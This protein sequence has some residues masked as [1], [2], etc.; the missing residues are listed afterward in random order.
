MNGTLVGYF[1]PLWRD[2]GILHIEYHIQALLVSRL[3]ILSSHISPCLN[4]FTRRGV[5]PPGIDYTT[6]NLA[7]IIIRTYHNA[8]PAVRRVFNDR[9]I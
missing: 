8:P 4:K 6:S 1:G 7:G 9:L 3:G 2:K 5:K